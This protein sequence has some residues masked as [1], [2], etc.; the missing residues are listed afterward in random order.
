MAATTAT[1]Q[2][3]KTEKTDRQTDSKNTQDMYDQNT[4]QTAMLCL[5]IVHSQV[6]VKELRP[7]RITYEV[8]NF[9]HSR[10]MLCNC[11]LTHAKY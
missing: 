4:K 10:Y 1:T 8:S 3:A 11:T 9:L 5:C 2:T 6:R 7:L